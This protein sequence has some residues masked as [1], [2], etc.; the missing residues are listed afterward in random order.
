[1]SNSKRYFHDKIVLLLLSLNSFLLVVNIVSLLLRLESN[2]GSA[3]IVEYRANLGLSAFK[4]GSVY[5]LL[6]FIAFA[7]LVF[8]LHCILSIKIY[9]HRRYL[10]VA[11]L[12]LGLFLLLLTSVVS[13]ALLALR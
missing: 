10:A 1:M 4:T 8:V 13:N 3:Y 12:V 6:S 11:I 2:K 5:E 9:N 7:V